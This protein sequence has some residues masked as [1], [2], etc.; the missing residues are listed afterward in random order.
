MPYIFVDDGYPES[1]EFDSNYVWFN[2]ADPKSLA[3]LERSLPAGNCALIR[4]AE[5]V[6][7]RLAIEKTPRY[8]KF[9]R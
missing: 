6:A 1:G 3:A 5:S 9:W 8:W 2:A 4:A 7:P